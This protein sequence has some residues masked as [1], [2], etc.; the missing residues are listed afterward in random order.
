MR[1]VWGRPILHSEHHLSRDACQRMRLEV[2]VEGDETLGLLISLEP[3]IATCSQTRLSE[4]V[5]P[6][7]TKKA[8]SRHSRPTWLCMEKCL[9]GQRVFLKYSVC[10]NLALLY[11]SLIGG[12]SAPLITRVLDATGYLTR[13]NRD[14]VWGRLLDTFH[15]VLSCIEFDDALEV[16]GAGWTSVVFVRMLHSRVRRR[17]LSNTLEPWPVDIAGLPLNQMDMLATLLS[18]SINVIDVIERLGCT[19]SRE[20]QLDYLHLWRYIGFLIGV[21]TSHLEC[22]ETPE[23]AKGALESLVQLLLTPTSRSGEIAKNILESVASRPPL[24]WSF[25]FHSAISRELLG[26]PLADSLCI[27]KTGCFDW[28]CLKLFLLLVRLAVYLLPS[29]ERSTA[30]KRIMLRKLLVSQQLSLASSSR[31]GCPHA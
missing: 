18:F 2:D 6:H 9:R 8:L 20:E 23:S 19:V 7:L 27:S 24:R 1:E 11:S 13:P 28:I 16:G 21:H 29:D 3:D 4:L 10:A 25:S 22:L 17:I 15:M 30:R 5:L 31:G 14:A 12:F 26:H